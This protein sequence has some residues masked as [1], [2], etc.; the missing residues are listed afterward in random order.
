MWYAPDTIISIVLVLLLLLG[1]KLADWI[2]FRPK[3]LEKLLRQQGFA[4]NSYRIL[5]GDLKERAAMRE[6]AM[7]KPMNFSNHIAPRVIPSIYHTIQRYGK[8]SFMWLGPIPRVHIMDPEQLKTVF[9]FYNDFQKPTMNPFTKLLVQGIVNL[10]GEKWVKH[11]KI[12][13]PA[14]HL[15]KL[16]DMV[17]AFYHSCNEMVSKWESM[18]SK[19]GSCE[20]DVMP[21]LKNMAS[22]VISRTAFGSSYEKGKKIFKLQTELTNFVIQTTLGIYIPGWRF[23]PTKLN[24]KMKEISKEITTLILG[25]MDEREKSM[26]AGEA[27]QTDLLSILMESNMNEIKQHGN[28]KDI[29]MSIEDVIEECKLF[30]IAGQETTATL[31]VWTMILLSSYSEWQE[32]A[33][34]EVFEIFG[35]KQP[36]YDGLNRLKVVT[37]IFNEVL[38]LY[39][40]GSLFVRIVRKE[41]RLGN[42]TLPGGVM[43]GLPIV[44]IQR[45]PELWGE[46]AHEF[47][48]E[49]FSGGVSKA[50]K[51]PS[52]F[53]PFGWGP[54][55]CI[56]QTFAM[57]EAKMALSMIL[58]RF[59]FEL[60]P[61][62]THSPIAS[63]TTQPQHGAHIILHKL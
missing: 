19:E 1:W 40:P 37:M 30:Y 41:T 47:N 61:S 54:R 35:N 24:R 43:L 17:P 34:A 15:E 32:R 49:R 38:R 50:T 9:S 59:S 46:D 11:R 60:S 55:I 5:H 45:D 33:R 56:G 10:D 12:I 18:V 25:I 29:G 62:Y 2:W 16:K 42:L 51:N 52:A 63:L 20:L 14:F 13:N 22:D 26:K 7:S 53:I 44:L 58:Q 6:E 39:P 31:L 36:N 57:I 23:L 27:I 3:K 48:P 8:N 28:K 4:G 21:Y